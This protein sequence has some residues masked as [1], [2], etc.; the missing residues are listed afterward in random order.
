M[1]AFC[2]ACDAGSRVETEWTGSVDTLSNGRIVVNNPAE[3]TWDSSTAWSVEI[4]FRI[5]SLEGSGADLFGRISALEVDES[6][7]I[8][9]LESQAHELRVFDASG[10][11]V[12]TVGREGSGPGE[13]RSPAGMAWSP[14]GNLWIVDP[15]NI[16]ISVF[17][18]T[19]VFLT[20]Y[21]TRGGYTTSPWQG[22]FDPSGFFH[23]SGYDLVGDQEIRNW[24]VRFDSLL[25][26]IDT[27]VIPRVDVHENFF[28]VRTGGS[29][30]RAGIPYSP[31]I[32]WRFSPAGQL[33]FTNTADYTIYQRTMSGDTVKIVSCEF[34][35][36]PVTEA[37]VDGV[38]AGLENFVRR[39]GRVDRSRIPRLRPSLVNFWVDDLGNLWVLPM[40]GDV[41]GGYRADVF[42]SD[43]LFLG[44]VRLP[45][46][47]VNHPP[48]IIRGDRI[49]SVIP[50]EFDVPYVVV[51]AIHKPE[52]N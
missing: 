10:R 28:E 27:I 49:Y 22:G 42:D 31:M 47:L 45:M 48:S 43:G 33:W 24:L 18:T 14:E 40:R 5:G 19:G 21:R 4:Q 50:G 6:G 38:M 52:L 8:Y 17:D 32:R 41:S 30:Y 34:E 16:R 39:G 2:V 20:S 36:Q 1:V 25:N 11:H 51:A 23:H 35:R 13:F 46:W 26:P 15:E 37:D 12:R 3:G 29:V 9:V 7:R 44:A